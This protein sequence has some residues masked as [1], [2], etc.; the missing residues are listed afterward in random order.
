MSS[1]AWSQTTTPE[2]LPGG[3]SYPDPQCTRPRV[4][5]IRP[6]VQL[7]TGGNAVDSGAIGSYN[8]KVRTFNRDAAA[9]NSCMHAYIDKANRDVKVVQEKANADLKQI[10]ERANASMK[11]IQDKIRQAVA[12]ANDIAAGLDNE[13]A[14]LR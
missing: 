7:N 14:K 9:Y 5:M 3:I 1:G 12:D 4:N 11:V 13:T 10:T 8:S 6:N 2:A